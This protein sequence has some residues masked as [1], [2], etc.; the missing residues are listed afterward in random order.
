MFKCWIYISG[1]ENSSQKEGLVS[2][3]EEIYTKKVLTEKEPL[4]VNSYL[5]GM[6]KFGFFDRFINT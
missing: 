4:Q 2:E 3:K 5:P 1:E 6:R